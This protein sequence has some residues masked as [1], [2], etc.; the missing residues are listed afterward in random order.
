MSMMFDGRSVFWVQTFD[1]QVEFGKP[2]RWWM[3]KFLCVLH[4]AQVTLGQMSVW[5]TTE[6]L[7]EVLGSGDDETDAN[8]NT[9]G[10]KSKPRLG[11][12]SNPISI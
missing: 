6:T 4:F 11:P 5:N 7:A 1:R 8:T 10:S 9:S 2:Q 3:P 12:N